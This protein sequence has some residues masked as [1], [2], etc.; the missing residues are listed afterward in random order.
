[1]AAGLMCAILKWLCRSRR[2]CTP[3]RKMSYLR[4]KAGGEHFVRTERKIR[5]SATGSCSCLNADYWALSLTNCSCT[6]ACSTLPDARKTDART[7]FALAASS[8]HLLVYGD[9]R[10]NCVFEAICGVGWCG[11]G[12]TFDCRLRD[13]DRLDDQV[14]LELFCAKA[15][16]ARL[17]SVNDRSRVY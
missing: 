6:L 1:M 15:L 7:I 8:R 3:V 16:R 4:E 11:L 2:L 13:A 14:L 12:Q 9:C 5:G 17:V 10:T